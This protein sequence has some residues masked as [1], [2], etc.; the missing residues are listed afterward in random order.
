[1]SA[2]HNR[3]T[4]FR[5]KR[6]AL[7]I[8]GGLGLSI[9]AGAAG[10]ALE[11]VVVTAQKRQESLQ[12][13]PIAVSAFT[14]TAI[15]DKG[16]QNIAEVAAFTPN[17]VFD[18]TSP[19]SG[20]SSGAVVFIR[21]IG[22]T[23]FSLTTDPGVG[24][25]IDGVY[26]SRSAGGVLDVL[27]V[28]RIE[29]LRGPQGTL[30]GRNTIGGAISI[31]SRKPA[32]TL[33]GMLELT[34][35]NF[36]RRDARGSI[37]IPLTARLRSTFAVSSKQRDGYVDRVLIGDKLGDE[38]Q[39]AL[40]GTL[41][42]D[43]SDALEFQLSLDHTRIDEQSAG[44]SLAGFT[45]G[46]GTVGWSLANFGDVGQGLTALSQYV[47]SDRDRSFA[48]GRSGT[49]LDITGGS[50]IT[51]LRLGNADLKYTVAL[52]ETDGEFFR[53]PDNSPEVITETLNPDYDHRQLSHELQ[54]TGTALDD[55]LQYIAGLYWFEEE[56]TDNVFV[57]VH[58][59]TPDLGAGFPAVISNFADVDN[60]SEA[61][62]LQ[63]GWSLNDRWSVTGGV[64]HT[65]DEKRFDYTQYIG[66]DLDG[67][68]L[69]FFPGAVNE[70]GVFSPGLAPLVGDG[71]GSTRDAFEETTYKLGL[72]ATLEDGTLLYYSFSQ[73]FKS[74][75][76]VLRYVEAVPAIRSFEPETLDSHEVGLKWQSANDRL[77]LNAALF[78]ADYDQVQVTFFDSLGGPITANAGTVDIHGLELELT[79]MLGDR[80]LLEAGYGY[81]DASYDEIN[82]IPGLSLAIDE[83]A[84]LVNTPEQTFNLGLEYS[85][86]RAGNEWVV[87]V[88]YSYSDDVH[89]DSQ[90]S[91][92][93]FQRAYDNW[94]ASLR[95]SIGERIDLVLFGKNLADERY[96]E[97]GDSNFGLGFHEA[98]Y[99][100]PREYGI[101]ARY[102]FL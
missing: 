5:K 101:T 25:Y 13:T 79:A 52:R 1:M 58:L 63:L 75:G 56:G 72:E 95:Y 55:R 14:A 49:R 31:T 50:L 70:E 43:A 90:N 71:S 18:T 19:V 3:G 93:L 76:F 2:P 60:N 45:P 26:M 74:G 17:L 46:A 87:R 29:V 77:R 27:D 83:T 44:S 97:S 91:P 102:R 69:P 47:A 6:S 16:I 7:A 98:N 41:V 23:D 48:T 99:N 8:A 21:G 100:R 96:I 22:N 38:D 10:A 66:A 65:R 34:A 37:D 51:S 24:T 11:E 92:F 88:D 67:G 64:R 53:D 57:R 42:F 36:D 35:G 28:E 81:I 9:G 40:R 73:G 33:Q 78:H 30:F 61:A 39:L 94:N 85:W 20:L 82:P 86:P 54:L 15:Q 4:V 80:L 32:D 12:D 89:N 62:Y 84:K 68:P 59:P